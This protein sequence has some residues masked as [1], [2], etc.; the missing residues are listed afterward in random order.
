[1]TFKVA[2]LKKNF[3]LAIILGLF[4][5]IAFEAV[6]QVKISGRVTDFLTNEPIPFVNVVFKGIP[7]GGRT[8]VN[9]NYSIETDTPAD[10]LMASYVGYKKVTVKVSKTKPVQT[11][12]FVLR[13]NKVELHEVVVNAGENPALILLRKIQAN[14]EKNDRNN[15]EAYQYETYN[16]MEFDIN[17]ISQN[18][19]NRKILKPFAFI[20]DK[21]DSSESNEKPFLPM[22][23]SESLSDVYY[24]S[25][26][27]NKREI[28]KATKVSGLE[29]AS[30]NQFMGDMYQNI[31]LY[32]NFIPMFNKG[33]VSPLAN[34]GTLYYKYYLLDSVFFGNQWC[35]KIKFKPRR[36]Q[37][38]TFVGD[39]W[40]HDTTF[41]LKKINM[42]VSEG[43]N[44]NFIEDIVIAREYERTNNLNWM[45][46]K[47]I[48]VVNFLGDKDKM[49]FIGRKTTSYKDIVINQ[50]KPPEFF[51]G[52]EAV[53]VADDARDK[54]AAYWTNARHDSL[55]KR[56]KAIYQMVDTIKTLPAFK[57]YLD[58]V[59]LIVSGYKKV[60]MVE[61]GPYFNVYS[62]NG[63]EGHR[64]RFGGRTSS[65]FSTNLILD[66]YVAYGTLDQKIKYGG[67]LQYYLSKKPRVSVGF[68]YKNDVELI[69]ASQNAFK[70]DNILASVLRRIP[71]TKLTAVVQE[72][73][74][75]ERDWWPGFSSRI[76]F[77]HRRF[78]PRGTLNYDY[79]VHPEINTDISNRIRT[80]DVAFYT[81]FAN[82]EKFLEGKRT[83][84]SLGTKYPIFQTEYV[85]GVKNLLGSNFGY[86]KIK[87][88]IEQKV[89]LSPIGYFWY[90]VEAGQ[91]FGTIPYP[92]LEVH[93]GNE[94]YTLDKFAFNLMNYYEFVSD[95]YASL[96]ITHHFNGFFLDKIPVMRK[97]KW[98]E[99]AT[100]S[101]LMGTMSAANRNLSVNKN[102]FYTLEKPYIEVGTGIENI[103]K[104]IRV[105]AV[106]RLTHLDHPNISQFGIR[107]N[108]QILF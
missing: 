28:I 104:L 2:S 95:R 72:K 43:A 29:N 10:S 101:G 8:D 40:V 30:I 4:S 107:A 99:V 52:N 69:G 65:D 49:G 47:D 57:T 38:L 42:R 62:Y 26:P 21:M 81:R 98:R 85:L 9:G 108:L 16:K 84:V 73:A 106:W 14:R 23:I 34:V 53:V 97:L 13:Q 75:Y 67:G 39:F 51:K 74:F 22:F 77:I 79:Y 103:F 44:I 5:A 11:F 24:T 45:V 71:F 91:T 33:F 88:R 90:Y 25:H 86:Q 17:N 31:N 3:F 7:V 12:N 78:A 82:K 94:T 68:S 63:V 50:P 46:K 27:V 19:K 56:E 66:G 1:M 55:A 61:I 58:V 15:L 59:T 41:A 64:F 80:T 18:F 93:S 96:Q 32:D 105:D 87:L 92:L 20:F 48:F 36:K 83:R 100:F 76:S 102:A 70:Q 6:G 35:Y 37:D 89:R 60:G 54:D